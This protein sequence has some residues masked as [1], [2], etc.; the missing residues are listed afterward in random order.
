[1]THVSRVRSVRGPNVNQTRIWKYLRFWDYYRMECDPQHLAHA[2]PTLR[3]CVGVQIKFRRPEVLQIA[4]PNSYPK[5]KT[6]FGVTFI[7]GPTL[8]S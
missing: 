2:P 6:S 4:C 1:M 5:C 7:L 3:Q 8:K